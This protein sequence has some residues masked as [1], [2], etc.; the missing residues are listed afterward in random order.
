MKLETFSLIKLFITP[1]QL[2]SHNFNAFMVCPSQFCQLNVGLILQDIY[3][4]DNVQNSGHY[5]DL[6]SHYTLSLLLLAYTKKKKKLSTVSF[7]NLFVTIHTF[8][9]EEYKPTAKTLNR[10]FYR[11]Q[12]VNRPLKSS[13]Q[14]FKTDLARLTATLGRRNTKSSKNTTG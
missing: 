8:S 6:F 13:N 5:R 3:K 1:F 2:L 10:T 4:W 12:L 7:Y 9:A 11:T 14:S